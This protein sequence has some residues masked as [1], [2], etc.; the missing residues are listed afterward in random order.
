MYIS[1]EWPMKKRRPRL[2]SAILE[3]PPSLRHFLRNRL[4]VRSVLVE[5][6]F[7]KKA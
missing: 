5:M 1:Y 6:T 3:R 4:K 7:S 2:T